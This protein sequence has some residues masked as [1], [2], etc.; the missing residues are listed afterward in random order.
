MRSL[1]VAGLL[2]LVGCK[3][4]APARAVAPLEAVPPSDGVLSLFEPAAD[5]C[6]WRRLDVASGRSATVASFAGTCVGA[7]VAFSPD[8]QRAVV[9]F[10]PANVQS[11]GMG[12]S[13][14]GKPGYPDEPVD[15]AAKSRLFLVTIASGAVTTLPLP[16]FEFSELGLDAKGVL[17]LSL[18]TVKDEEV[19][20]GKTMVDGKPF[21]LTPAD[22][23]LVALAHASR[24]EKDAWRRVET[25]Q[26]TTGWDYGPGVRDLD[27]W[28]ALGPRST[29]LLDTHPD[30][31][32]DVDEAT[33]KR[34]A[35]LA[36]KLGEGSWSSWG[37]PPARLFG[38]V[39]SGEFAHTTGYLV[40]EGT[41]PVPAPKVGFTDGDLVA[42]RRKG[43]LLLVASGGAGT[44]PRVYRFGA[45]TLVWSSDAAR[46]AAF[47]P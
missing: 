31:A 36:P 21:A 25:K 3:K 29:L 13:D 1:L 12:G 24:F 44:H 40:F 8:G 4:D 33:A 28:D 23:G 9:W 46:G 7:R 15:D 17:A 43:S 37:T 11:A 19:A 32:A 35:S 20:A 47:W 38:W 45:P 30:G 27:A 16:A 18:E 22:E 41:P 42:V 39:V 2:V 14:V 34:L 5:R 10:D 26:T 6:E